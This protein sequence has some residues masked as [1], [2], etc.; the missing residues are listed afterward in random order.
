MRGMSPD[1]SIVRVR[2]IAAYRRT[3]DLE[4]LTEGLRKAGMPE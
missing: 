4:L 3:A 2:A 1:L